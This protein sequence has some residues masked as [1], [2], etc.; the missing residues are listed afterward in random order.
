[1]ADEEVKKDDRKICSITNRKEDFYNEGTVE[2]G[3]A[4]DRG[5]SGL[6]N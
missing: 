2:Q 4:F 5:H 6:E 1:M 3:R